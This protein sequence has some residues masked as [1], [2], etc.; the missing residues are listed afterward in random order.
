MDSAYILIM[1]ITFAALFF[2]T[3]MI[4]YGQ[5]DTSAFM[6]KNQWPKSYQSARYPTKAIEA[7][8]EGTVLVAFDV[9]TLCRITN[10]RIV[11]GIGY[12]C[13][14]NALKVIND[15]IELDLMQANKFACHPGTMQVPV[16]FTLGR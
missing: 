2:S 9:D 5:S 10:K 7:G 13:D 1:R 4:G 11:Q 16:R 8:I 12:G 3:V 6:N 15:K 14:E